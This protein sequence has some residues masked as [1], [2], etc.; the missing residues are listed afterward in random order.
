MEL[1]EEEVE[2]WIKDSILQLIL[3]GIERD[4]DLD[5][6]LACRLGC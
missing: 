1:K 4:L 2:T 5:L 6:D 3:N